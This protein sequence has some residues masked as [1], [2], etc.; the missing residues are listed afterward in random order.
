MPYRP[1]HKYVPSDMPQ[2]VMTDEEMFAHAEGRQAQGGPV[3]DAELFGPQGALVDDRDQNERYQGYILNGLDNA[4]FGYGDEA[5]AAGGALMGQGDYSKNLKD[6]EAKHQRYRDLED[7]WSAGN[8]ASGAAGFV[9]GTPAF[10]GLYKGAGKIVKGLTGTPTGAAGKFAQEVAALGLTGGAAGEI[11]HT[12]RAQGS[13]GSRVASLGADAMGA[14]A[15]TFM[16][17]L[18]NAAPRLA[19]NVGLGAVAGAAAPAATRGGQ[20][21]FNFM[22]RD[23]A[24][25]AARY[26][27]EKFVQ[28]GKTVDEFA[29]EMEAAAKSGKPIAPVDIAPQ[30]VRDAGTA[31]ARMPGEGRDKATKFLQERHEAQGERLQK[32]FQSALGGEPGSFVKTVEQINAQRAAEAAPHYERAFANKAPVS[33]KKLFELTNRPSGKEALQRGLKM[34][35]DEGIDLSELVIRDANGNITGYT[36]KAL[37]YGKMALDDMIESAR[38]QGN[39]MAAS[40][41]TKLKK[42]WLSEMDAINPDYATARKIYAGHSASRNA[43]EAGRKAVGYHPDQIE[44]ELSALSEHE[45]ELYKLGFSQRIIEDIENTPDKANAVGRI[46][47]NKMKRDRLM[48]ILGPDKYREIAERF[49]LE[50]KMFETYGDIYRNSTTAQ[51]LAAQ[52]DLNTGIAGLSPEAALGIG[53]SMATGNIRH[54]L[55]AVG[56]TQFQYILQGIGQRTRAQVVKMLF[57]NDP[58]EVKAGLEMIKKHYGAAERFQN[59]QQNVGAAAAAQD[60]A[61]KT[62]GGGTLAGAQTAGGMAAGLSPF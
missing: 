31:A 25:K 53:R 27:A 57:S 45:Q 39:D 5:V 42:D 28:S 61:R 1:H 29:A 14:P 2:K 51:K 24:N 38:R 56:W 54:F 18:S 11:T 13:V 22:F 3:S 52:E 55:D 16:E 6:I 9:A 41:L 62:V 50:S 17:G 43:L 47:G 60:Q 4:L 35:Q 46:F 30:Q 8:L 7:D 32:D 26:L 12:G 21:L 58:A 40:N 37:H 23:P 33:S 34:A 10:T 20:V 49:G 59:M 15:A 19:M 44:S 36:T 48:K